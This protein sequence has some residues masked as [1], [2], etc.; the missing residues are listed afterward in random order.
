MTFEWCFGGGL[1]MPFILLFFSAMGIL[2]IKAFASN[3]IE[4]KQNLG[5]WD[6][7]A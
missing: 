7:I 3:L 4:M 1:E 5:R 2:V 6:I